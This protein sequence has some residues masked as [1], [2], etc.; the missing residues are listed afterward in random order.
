M[1]KDK[2]IEEVGAVIP[3]K[4]AKEMVERY[5]KENPDAQLYGAL[6]GRD[7]LL[8]LMAYT[9]SKGVWCYKG[10][11]ENCEETIV[12]FPADSKGGILEEGESLE[13]NV[14]SRSADDA[15]DSEWKCPPFCEPPK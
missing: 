1:E 14:S 13:R 3:S 4:K 9:G 11:D 2:D 7:V 15:A 5:K 10:L 12:L 6:F 8:K